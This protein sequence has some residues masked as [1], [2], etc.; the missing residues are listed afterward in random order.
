MTLRQTPPPHIAD[1][2]VTV[3]DSH[4][5]SDWRKCRRLFW[6]R[7]IDGWRSRH[8]APPLIFGTALHEGFAAYE[9]SKAAGE[10]HQASLRTAVRAALSS[11]PETMWYGD[12][13]R[14]WWTLVSTIVKFYDVTIMRHRP[15]ARLA[16]GAPAIELP[17]R[18]TLDIDGVDFIY[19]GTIDRLVEQGGRV[20]PIDYKHTTSSYTSDPTKAL[21]KFRS[22][23]QAPGYIVGAWTLLPNAA[24]SIIYDVLEIQVNDIKHFSLEWDYPRGYLDEWVEN[25]ARDMEDMVKV[26]SS[27]S[28]IDAFRMTGTEDACFFCAFNVICHAT[29]PSKRQQWIESAFVRGWW[30]PL[31]EEPST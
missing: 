24:P 14:N 19:A 22:G 20:R 29:P 3:L 5:L 11:L 31:H 7:N 13:K 21:T 1:N 17:F 18:I 2:L 26:A 30:D 6:Y 12:S 4:S 15:T 10:R 16:S 27:A 8:D 9:R 28:N 23:P 25:L